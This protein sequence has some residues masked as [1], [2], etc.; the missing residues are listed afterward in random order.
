MLYQLVF[1]TWE[2]SPA[3]YYIYFIRCN[4][5][6]PLR[7]MKSLLLSILTIFLTLCL[8][9]QSYRVYGKITNNKLEPLAF[10]SI[11][12]K[13]HPQGTTSKED[14]T[15]ELDVENGQYELVVSMIGYKSQV[16]SI[17]VN[18]DYQQNIMMEEDEAKNTMDDIV[19]K[20][21]VKDRAEEIV[22]G[23]IRNKDQVN[24]ASTPY[25]CQVYIKAVQQDSTVKKSKKHNSAEL[26]GE[27]ADL[28]R[29]AMS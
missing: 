16:L 4:F 13:D 18:K 3:V 1:N 8:H 20:V 17:A 22:K 28:E 29:M 9:A 7:F 19:I 14:G 25:S 2:K 11:Q 21:K 6:C 27:N 24:T 12:I 26:K 23:V 5:T 10:V 15:Y